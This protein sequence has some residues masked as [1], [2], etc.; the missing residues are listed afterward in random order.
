MNDRHVSELGE[1]IDAEAPAYLGPCSLTSYDQEHALG[2]LRT[3]LLIRFAEEQ[4]GRWSETGQARCPCHLSIG[5]EAVATGVAAA[6]QRGDRLFG[7]HRSH[8]HYL[9][10]GGELYGLLAEVSGAR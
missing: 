5:Q 8:A 9:A 6:L 2:F 10:A 4:I 3:M 1:L 7:N